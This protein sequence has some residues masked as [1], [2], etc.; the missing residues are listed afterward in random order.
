MNN[1]KIGFIGGGNMS[2]AVIRGILKSNIMKYNE[3][4]ISEPSE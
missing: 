2:T 4:L 1:Y 3:I